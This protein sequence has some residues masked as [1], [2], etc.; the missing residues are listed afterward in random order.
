[1]N[2]SLFKRGIISIGKS[3]RIFFKRLGLRIGVSSS[4][5]DMFYAY[6]FFIDLIVK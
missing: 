4:L 2:E 6:L 5:K 3:S 1:M